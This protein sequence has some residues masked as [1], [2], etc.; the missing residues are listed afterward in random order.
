MPL[1]DKTIRAAQPKGKQYQLQDG[2]GL[3]V[4][5][6]PCGTKEFVLRYTPR[7]GKRKRIV[8]GKYPDTTLAR[9]RAEASEHRGRIYS[10][11]DPAAER[12]AARIQGETLTDVVD[13]YIAEHA[14]T[15]KPSTA[16]TYLSAIGR[17]TEWAASSR[18]KLAS[19]VTPA[20]LA[21]YRAHAV[22]LPRRVKAKGGS[23]RDVVS[24]GE[25]RGASA[26][27]CDLRATKTM[28]Q[29]LRKAGRL[30]SIGGSDAITDNLQLLT[31]EQAKPDPLK[32]AQLRKLLGA[33]EN[34]DAATWTMTRSEAQGMV[35]I[36]QTPRHEPVG[37]LVVLMLLSGMRLGEA[38]DLRWEDVD[39][40]EGLILVRARKT[41][42]E[43]KIDLGVSPALGRLLAVMGDAVEGAHVFNHTE[44]TA[45][46]ARLRLI[47]DYRAPAFLWSTRNSRPGERSAPTLRS[48]C[49]CYLTC[50]P[51]IYGAASLYMA[52][53]RQGHSAEV[54]QKH[55]LGALT[56]IPKDATTL[57]SAMQIERELEQMINRLGA[58]QATR[59]RQPP[60]NR[61][62]GATA[63]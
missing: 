47:S 10:G 9:A 32:V 60:S 30:P 4:L 42:Q 27:N 48:T 37:P 8:L 52:S 34:H 49:G 59:R 31:V 28:L 58:T 26:I 63:R 44:A 40:Q 15:W 33:C 36:G 11:A 51:S 22:K 14:E 23:R 54:A 20:T 6:L 61:S 13:R 50:A 57:E 3:Y 55:Y 29:A 43:R 35:E 12:T 17:F 19:D 38:L 2:G 24:T 7:G 18:V 1:T 53:V 56:R 5:V 16:K 39:L 45:G 25:R 41:H 21:A 62:F 46:S